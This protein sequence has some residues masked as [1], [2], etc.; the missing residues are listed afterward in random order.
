MYKGTGMKRKGISFIAGILL[1]LLEAVPNPAAATTTELFNF[2]TIVP[3]MTKTI[4]VIQTNVFPVGCQHFF[5]AVAGKGTLAV[6]IKNDSTA[7]ETMFMTGMAQSS[8][9]SVP[10]ARVGTSQGMISQIV[11]VGTGDAPYGLVWIY[12]GIMIADKDPA[13]FYDVRLSLEP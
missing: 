4:E 11:E 3:G 13:F 9:G 6:S 1:I 5:I 8:Y 12:C 2:A 7:H 10:I